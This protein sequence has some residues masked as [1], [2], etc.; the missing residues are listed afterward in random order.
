MNT[1][2]KKRKAAFDHEI[3]LISDDE[4]DDGILCNN[5]NSKNAAQTKSSNEYKD[6]TSQS[7]STINQETVDGNSNNDNLQAKSTNEYKDYNSQTDSILSA[8]LLQE[9]H[10]FTPKELLF[11]SVYSS[12][13][14]PARLLHFKL[15]NNRA[16]RWVRVTSLGRVGSEELEGDDALKSETDTSND[17]VAQ[18]VAMKSE[19]DTFNVVEDK[20]LGGDDI[21]KSELTLNALEFNANESNGLDCNDTIC[22]SNFNDTNSS[23]SE[24]NTVESAYKSIIYKSQNGCALDLESRSINVEF[25]PGLNGEDAELGSNYDSTETEVKL[26]SL[27]VSNGLEAKLVPSNTGTI[28]SELDSKLLDSGL[29]TES[30]DSLKQLN[31]TI[32]NETLESV[33]Q[34][35]MGPFPIIEMGQPSTVQEA[36]QLLK[37]SELL[38]ICNHH[39]IPTNGKKMPA[40]ITILVNTTLQQSLLSFSSKSNSKSFDSL[41]E[42]ILSK[43]G[44]LLKLTSIARDLF[45]R[46]Y[47]IYFRSTLWPDEDKFMTRSILAH[48]REDKKCR[49]NYFPVNV[50]RFGLFWTK[51]SELVEYAV[52]LRTELE[53]KD[54]E[55]RNNK[56]AWDEVLDLTNI[57]Y[58]EWHNII[59]RG[60]GHV[61]GIPWLQ[62][63]TP[64]CVLTRYIIFN[65]V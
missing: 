58:S 34:L 41:F 51:R 42:Q 3:I 20:E 7:H 30:F 5:G 64:G 40:L 33:R 56:D 15:L 25:V 13:S 19:T 37:R 59:S 2:D 61:T 26:N 9:S 43:T 1:N 6:Y 8:V 60:E 38:D 62:V 12:L 49:R 44:P 63:Y 22:V 54:I 24:L 21:K 48:V 55:G 65:Q 17:V 16:W 47:I 29:S 39:R 14:A 4:P 18:E 46:M 27:L 11:F 31:L 53:L 50:S 10:L 52:Y 23:A 57:L 45:H 28:K 35:N 36:L 32:L